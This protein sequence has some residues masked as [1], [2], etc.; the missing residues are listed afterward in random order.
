MSQRT[1]VIMG[2]ALVIG[3]NLLGCKGIGVDRPT[4]EQGKAAILNTIKEEDHAGAIKLLS[5]RKT[6]GQDQ[7]HSGVKMYKMEYE[8]EIEFTRDCIG[9]ANSFNTDELHK[10]YLDPTF[11]SGHRAKVTGFIEFEKT[12]N[13]W[14]ATGV[15]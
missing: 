4:E 7:E 14:R 3:L 2:F 9:M 10:P 13:G 5:F 11:K 1:A 8:C 15:L 12:E 6:N